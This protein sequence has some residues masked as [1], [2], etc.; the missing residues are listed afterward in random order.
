MG[1]ESTWKL[2][3]RGMQRNEGH[4]DCE[5]PWGG[6]TVENGSY[7]NNGTFGVSPVIVFR[8]AFNMMRD[9]RALLPV[10]K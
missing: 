5:N 8:T 1:E 7:S 3:A 4:W 2:T 9:A 10:S 6:R